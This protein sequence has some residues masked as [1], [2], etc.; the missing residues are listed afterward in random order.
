MCQ[1]CCKYKIYFSLMS[2]NL[3]DLGRKYLLKN[4][5]CNNLIDKF[6]ISFIFSAQ[7]VLRRISITI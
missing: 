1:S 2:N 7:V 3:K 6:S 5:E 4:L